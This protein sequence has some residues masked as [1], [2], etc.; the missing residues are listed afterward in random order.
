MSG[1]EAGA[2]G[3]CGRGAAASA[4]GGARGGLPSAGAAHLREAFPVTGP[5]GGGKAL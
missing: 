5:G 1:E 4:G 3:G 2:G